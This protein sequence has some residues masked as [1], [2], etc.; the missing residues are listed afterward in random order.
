MR[1]LGFDNENFLKLQSEK[2]NERI[3]EFGGKL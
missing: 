1:A 3:A 2:I